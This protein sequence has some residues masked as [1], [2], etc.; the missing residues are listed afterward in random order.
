MKRYKLTALLF[1][2]LAT[3]SLSSCNDW[4]DLEPSD[5]LTE[6]DLFATGDGYRNALNGVY[7][8]MGTSSMYGQNMSWGMVDAL[9]GLYDFSRKGSNSDYAYI[10]KYNYKSDGVQDMIDQVWSKTYNCIANCNQ[11]IQR[12]EKE[13][14]T[15]KF[16]KGSEEMNLI[17]GE[18]LALR[19]LLHF[20]ILRLFAPA[21]DNGTKYIPYVTTYP[22]TFQ[23]YSTVND[24]LEKVRKDLVDAKALVKEYE[25]AHLDW[26]TTD[27]RV[28]NIK[29]SS[30]ET[31]PDDLFFAFRAY[32]LNYYAISA[33]LARVYAY[34]GMYEEAFNESKVVIDNVGDNEYSGKLFYFTSSNDVNPESYSKVCNNKLFEDILFTLSN[35]K[36]YDNYDAVRN[37]SGNYK[38]YLKT[39]SKSA[40]FNDDMDV[41]SYLVNIEDSRYCYCNKHVDMSGSA[42]QYVE[43]MIPMIRVSELYLIRALY[44]Y[45]QGLNDKVLDEV[46]QLR[47]VRNCANTRLMDPSKKDWFTTGILEE[48]KRE[49][50]CEG[51]LFF[52]HKHLGVRPAAMK[53]DDLFVLPYPTSEE[54]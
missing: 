14:N 33:L 53:T 51:Q 45:Q 26:M 4:L 50:M 37:G 29:P 16:K 41:R 15:A 6:D 18:A 42:K 3:F 12:L 46:A 39:S 20:D 44:Y 38:F 36:L 25:E 32:R 31:A 28:K 2:F 10:S 49:F 43:D 47:K 24:V 22:C 23:E 35:Q 21:K 7:K 34:S 9:G 17:K 52:W 48:V 54:L 19:A 11:L 40:F 5:T 1:A 27:L 13:N 30:V 8:Q